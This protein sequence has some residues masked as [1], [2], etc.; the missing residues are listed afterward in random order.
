MK[1]EREERISIYLGWKLDKAHLPAF[2]R[3]A[4]KGCPRV[5]PASPTAETTSQYQ[6]GAESQR[7]IAAY[8]SPSRSSPHLIWTCSPSRPAAE[9]MPLLAFR[10]PH[11]P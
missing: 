8:V 3:L 4:G 7:P 11:V 2:I 10:T 5:A 9:I 1:Q 6:W